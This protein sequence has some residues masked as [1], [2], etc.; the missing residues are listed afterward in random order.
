MIFELFMNG[1]PVNWLLS[2]DLMS[3]LMG[4]LKM[5]GAFTL[6]D[7]VCMGACTRMHLRYV[8]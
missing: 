5:I 7:L 3:I 1:M 4:A 8:R 2:A 6:S